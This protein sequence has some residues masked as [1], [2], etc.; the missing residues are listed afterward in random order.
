M[1][2]H[3]P[4]EGW[5]QHVIDHMLPKMEATT[6]QATGFTPAPA[7]PQPLSFGAPHL[8][9][10]DD[11]ATLLP[12]AAAT[13]MIAIGQR[14][15]D[16]F[17]QVPSFDEVQEVRLEAIGYK[18]RISDL[19]RHASEGGFGLDASA[20]QVVAERRKLERAEK[21]LARLT[22]LKETR[23]V[24]WGAA[25]QLHQGVSG[26]V[27]R[28]VPGDCVI[29]SIED[30]PLSE[31]L[32]K[33]EGGRIEAAVE[34]FRHRRREQLANLHRVRSS[35][36]PSSLAK[37]AAKE[38]IDRLADQGAPNLDA[39]IEHGMDIGFAMTR[40]TS[41]VY[42][43][44]APGAVAY[45]ETPDAIALMCWTLRDQLLA[46]INAGF[47]EIADD[48]N[49]LSQQQREEAEAQ[50]E[51]DMLATERLEV[52]CIWHA[53]ERGEIIDFRADTTPMAAIGVQLR[54]LPRAAPPP[55]SPGLSWD[56]R[57]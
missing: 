55:S 53:A 7:N 10:L 29:E 25:G 17:A 3:G 37:V 28:A 22:E 40:L 41:S 2:K 14:A 56:L 47:D 11:P 48:K 51:R 24:R 6:E 49:A 36:W 20:P 52:A 27:L 43:V 5:R 50:I 39:A 16:L 45:A 21:E 13:K 1:A 23:S 38:L 9:P 26:W 8:A 18:N 31:L 4:D 30:A 34:R 57:R 32:T 19:T 33:A 35:P 44:D 54:T 12:D 15:A 46:K 42:N